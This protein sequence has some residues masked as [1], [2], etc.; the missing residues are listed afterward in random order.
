MNFNPAIIPALVILSVLGC[1]FTMGYML[2]RRWRGNMYLI[3]TVSTGMALLSQLILVFLTGS[4]SKPSVIGPMQSFVNLLSFILLQGGFF[5][6]FNP[7]LKKEFYVFLLATA[8]SL[9]LASFFFFVS[10]LFVGIALTILNIGFT[11]FLYFGALP[12]LTK[13]EKFLAVFI[14]NVCTSISV[15]LYSI[16]E[17]PF[18][19]IVSFTL[20]LAT[21]SML[22]IILFDRIIDLMQAVSYSSVTDGLTGLYQK[23]YFKKKVNEAIAAGKPCS[24]IF[25]DL[26]NFKRLNDT[27]GHQI[28]DIMLKLAAKIMKEVCD[29]IGIGGRYGGEEIVA[30]ITDHTD[31]RSDPAIV[32][33]KYRA[34]IESE[35]KKDGYYPITVSV[36]FSRINSDAT[37]ADEFIRQADDAMYLSKTSGKNKISDFAALRGEMDK[38]AAAMA[39]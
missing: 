7:K 24:V 4:G 37:D 1:M 39:P 19:L 14:L 13:R 8:G 18:L 22:F 38:K 26:D 32:A 29:E 5:H 11:V 30:L 33:E 36:G 35:S 23:H 17:S 9:L 12:R 20:G 27:Q 6:I 10:A 31:H 16:L 3:F 2:Y 28:G 15:L 34:R 25:S 21:L